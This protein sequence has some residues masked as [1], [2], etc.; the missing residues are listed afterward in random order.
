MN[1]EK[2]MVTKQFD[3]GA[4]CEPLVGQLKGLAQE[5]ELKRLDDHSRAITRL[6]IFGLLTDLQADSARHRLVKLV[7]A[8]VKKKT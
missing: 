4:L 2:K 3:I 7:Q 6:H 1:E 8:A 5:Q